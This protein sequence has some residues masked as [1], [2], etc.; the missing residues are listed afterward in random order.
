MKVFYFLFFFPK[1]SYFFNDGTQGHVGG[2]GVDARRKQLH[3]AATVGALEGQTQR[4]PDGVVGRGLEQRV[5]AALAE[6]VRAG[7]HARVTEQGVAHGAGEVL[8]QEFHDVSDGESKVCGVSAREGSGR[9]AGL[10]QEK[11]HQNN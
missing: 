5:Q 2:Q 8:L 1:W 10:K 11:L 7:Q 6:G 3:H 4:P 9:T